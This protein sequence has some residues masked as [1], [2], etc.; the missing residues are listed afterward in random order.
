MQTINLHIYEKKIIP[1]LHAKQ[2]DV[3]RK[4]KVII[5]DGTDGYTIPAD[6]NLS[7]WYEGASGVGNYTDIG[8]ESAIHV[9][10]NVVIVEMI[11]QMLNNAGDG[12]LCLI[13]A[14]ADGD[15]IGTWNIPYS[16]EAVPGLGSK[17]AEQHLNALADAQ[18]RAENS[19]IE[20][21]VYAQD[22]SMYR[23]E[24]KNW[25]E[26]AED[27]ANSVLY[28]KLSTAVTDINNGV[29][30]NAVSALEQGKVKVFTDSNGATTVMLLDDVAEATQIDVNKDI[31]LVLAGHTI[32]FTGTVDS[33][34][35]GTDTDCVI[36]G[37][38]SG[39]AIYK[40]VTG[41]GTNTIVQAKG[42]KLAIHG[43]EY[44]LA[45]PSTTAIAFR[46]STGYFGM[47]GAT[48]N[49]SAQ[50]N[51]THCRAVQTT[52]DAIF[53]K[54][55]INAMGAK[56]PIGVAVGGGVVKITDCTINV[57]NGSTETMG[58]WNMTTG[59]TLIVEN[60]SIS[61]ISTV[62]TRGLK[63]ATGT[64]THLSNSVIFAD[65]PQGH[66][67]A[68]GVAVGVYTNGTL[69]CK[70]TNVT[71]T[72]SGISNHGKLYVSGGTFM[73]STHG[74]F[75]L[76]HGAD[77]IA[78]IRDATIRC[79]EYNGQFADFWESGDNTRLGAL[80][81]GGGTGANSSNVTAFLDGC[82]LNDTYNGTDKGAWHCLVLRGT[83]GETGHNI[84]ISNSQ[85]TGY[86]RVDN[87]TMKLNVGV[88]TNITT[89][90]LAG[91]TADY[92]EFTDKLYRKHHDSEALNGKD[93]ATLLAYAQ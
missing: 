74:G 23:D 6:A 32:S 76:A 31:H 93:F 24:A 73:G 90:T 63:T 10:D 36:D 7:V 26:A 70:D 58:V 14:N 13:M 88:G 27:A 87:E 66:V 4:F 43:G 65:A 56:N 5:T 28:A 60:S 91:S 71:G 51:A 57:T 38:A 69:F 50:A 1:V 72:H 44:T 81:V 25:A 39:S 77:G 41:S 45:E 49:C 86:I 68:T 75:Y 85:V 37:T 35:F 79:G 33:L 62:T 9:V 2:G 52:V 92:T 55:T 47:H 48:V 8:G 21:S 40:N 34:V 54:C 80:Y 53:E 82:V 78:Y 17:P 30:D 18:K 67:G 84:S 3:G 89:G 46:I 29:T 12:K 59:A 22:A 11:A 83:D 19:A 16:V 64:Q 42:K 61:A 15:E 20:A